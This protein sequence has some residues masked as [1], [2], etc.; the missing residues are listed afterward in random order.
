MCECAVCASVVGERGAGRQVPWSLNEASWRHLGPAPAFP[1]PRPRS[2][3]AGSQVP[4]VVQGPQRPA[5]PAP[6]PRAE[7]YYAQLG[8][9]RN[10]LPGPRPSQCSDPGKRSRRQRG[11]FAERRSR[12]H[13]RDVCRPQ[14]QGQARSSRVRQRNRSSR[15]T[16]ARRGSAC[17]CYTACV[18]TTHAGVDVAAQACVFSATCGNV[19]SRVETY[20]SVL[21]EGRG[22]EEP[23][24]SPL[25]DISQ[26]PVVSLPQL[27]TQGE[28]PGLPGA[29]TLHMPRA[30]GQRAPGTRLSFL[31]AQ[32][33]W[34]RPR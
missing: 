15:E 16:E 25:G 1:R 19:R 26:V 23:W 22:R 20:T 27:P 17:A 32:W 29:V 18:G 3:P 12:T 9:D 2:S 30:P 10:R 33:S 28:V 31:S 14:C 34:L 8:T 7:G 6:A 5:P 21:H 24:A 4:P 11:P 13:L